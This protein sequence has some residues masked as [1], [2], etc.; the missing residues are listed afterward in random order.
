MKNPAT[1][2]LATV[3]LFVC[4]LIGTT[5]SRAQNPPVGHYGS[6]SSTMHP[7]AGGQIQLADLRVSGDGGMVGRI[8][9]S[10][11]ICGVWADFIGHAEGKSVMMSMTVGACG[12]TQ[13]A[14]QWQGTAWVGTYTSQYPDAGVVQ[15]VP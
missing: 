9:F 8:F 1:T 11:S 15:M 2:L 10:G 12:I 5:P 3:G 7:G 14:M 6:W 4:I 13:V